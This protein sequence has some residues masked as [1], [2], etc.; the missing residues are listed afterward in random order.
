MEIN[1]LDRSAPIFELLEQLE[2][3]QN[4]KLVLPINKYWKRSRKSW[5]TKKYVLEY[6]AMEYSLTI[7]IKLFEPTG[8]SDYDEEVC[9]ETCDIYKI[10]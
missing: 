6:H 5:V 2:L 1:R 3:P 8:Y 9:Y 4:G 10:W 7:C